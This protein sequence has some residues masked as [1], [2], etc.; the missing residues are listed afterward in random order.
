VLDLQL[1]GEDD[2]DD[3]AEPFALHGL[4]KYWL[5]D[6]AV[7]ARLAGHPDPALPEVLAQTGML[8]PGALGRL[9]AT[10]LG[11]EVARFCARLRDVAGTGA[12][13]VAVAGTDYVVTG[14]LAGLTPAA[15]VL[16]R[17]ARLKPKDRLRAWI[18]HVVLCAAA[19]QGQSLPRRTLVL[20]TDREAEAASLCPALPELD[21]L[22]RGYR[23][24]L[25]APLPFFEHASSE[26][27]R[28][29]E[30]GA[31]ESMQQAR[32][33]FAPPEYEDAPKGRNDLPDP[34][35]EFCFR[36]QDPLALPAFA[37]WSQQV[38]GSAWGFVRSEED[39]A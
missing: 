1:P 6:A 15:L 20:G 38:Y 18:H 36:D 35:I 11:L 25:A 39:D 28:L 13:A 10:D 30:R 33:R 37:A 8:P 3:D 2:R 7:Q 23:L 17:T 16:W 5:A 34:W 14:E 4:D 12:A 26:Y 19:D 27:C 32:K 24:G 22:V 21:R 9:H 31:E 29:P